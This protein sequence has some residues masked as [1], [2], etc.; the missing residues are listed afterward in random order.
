[1]AE[2][3]GVTRPALARVIGELE[4]EGVIQAERKEITITDREKL[5]KLTR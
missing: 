2:F 4:K 1:M 3:F 5:I